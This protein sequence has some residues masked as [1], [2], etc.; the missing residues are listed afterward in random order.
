MTTCHDWYHIDVLGI[1][2]VFCVLYVC[3]VTGKRNMSRVSLASGSGIKLT[4]KF[5]I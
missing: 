1:F 5:M 2:C 3:A 4:V